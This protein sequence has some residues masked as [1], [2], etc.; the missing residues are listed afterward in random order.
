MLQGGG[1]AICVCTPG[2]EGWRRMAFYKGE[3]SGQG[4]F[5]QPVIREKRV[6]PPHL[7]TELQGG[8]ETEMGTVLPSSYEGCLQREEITYLTVCECSFKR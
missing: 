8:Q 4:M 6:R 5:K 2:P 3:S 1:Q 7:G